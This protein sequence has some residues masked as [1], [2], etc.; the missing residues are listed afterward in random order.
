MVASMPVEIAFMVD[1]IPLISLSRPCNLTSIIL[2][3]FLLNPASP[4]SNNLPANRAM[5]KTC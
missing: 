2:L 5:D 4:S 1:F 3:E